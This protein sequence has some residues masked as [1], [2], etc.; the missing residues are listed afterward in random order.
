MI[1]ETPVIEE[2]PAVADQP[3][4]PA[5]IPVLQSET[6]SDEP[7]P[8]AQAPVNVQH[9][10]TETISEQPVP[11][12]RYSSGT[13]IAVEGS[14]MA[15]WA[16]VNLLASILTVL[17]ALLML[18]DKRAN[19]RAVLL[20]LVAAVVSVLVFL[21]TENLANPMVLVDRWTIAMLALLA[22]NGIMI[23]TKRSREAEKEAA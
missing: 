6:V 23:L 19:N 5:A 11:L 18:V 7:M 17:L 15:G 9:P 22:V 4:A 1:E 12:V 16:L 20:G 3:H 2:A 10:K 14:Q 13:E 8:M 21:F